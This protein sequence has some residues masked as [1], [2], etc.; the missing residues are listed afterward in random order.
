MV[1]V[2]HGAVC[3][4]QGQSLV[5]EY[6][7]LLLE[8]LLEL[9]AEPLGSAF[10]GGVRQTPICRP[11]FMWTPDLDTVPPPREPELAMRKTALRTHARWKDVAPL[12]PYCGGCAFD[13]LQDGDFDESHDQALDD[14][15]GW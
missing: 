14:L 13:P 15:V 4:L 7:P 5:K 1:R 8:Q 3:I 6:T 2:F 12:P 10:P 9:K 11:D